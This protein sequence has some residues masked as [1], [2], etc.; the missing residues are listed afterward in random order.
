MRGKTTI[1]EVMVTKELGDPFRRD[2]L[3]LPTRFLQSTSTPRSSASAAIRQS[4]DAARR[5][6]RCRSDL[7]NAGRIAPMTASSRSASIRIATL[8]WP[9]LVGWLAR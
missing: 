2:A 4:A 7:N 9:E 5:G 1:L 3:A 8:L 6:A